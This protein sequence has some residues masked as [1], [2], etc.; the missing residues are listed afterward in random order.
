MA[1]EVDLQAERDELEA[2]FSSGAFARSPIV[3][4]MLRYICETHF[5]GQ[6]HE[7]KE[8]NIAVEAFGR[9]ADFDQTRDSIVRVEAHRLRKRLHEYYNGAGAS[10]EIQI[11][12]PPG[13]YVPQFIRRGEPAKSPAAP[14]VEPAVVEAPVVE[15]PVVPVTLATAVNGV[16]APP[17]SDPVSVHSEPARAWPGSLTR[18][19]F[20]FA[21]ALV[22]IGLIMWAPV[23]RQ[24]SVP[25]S[26]AKTGT[27]TDVAVLP[28]DEVR[29]LAGTTTASAVDHFGNTWLGDRYFQGGIARTVAPRPIVYTRDPSFYYHSREGDFTYDIPLKQGN[30][31]LRLYFAET[32]FGENNVAGGGETSRVFK[33][34]ANGSDLRGF[35]DVVADAGGSNTADVKIFKDVQPADD[36]MLHLKFATI[37]TQAP[38]VNAIELVPSRRG[39]IRP[40]RI[41]ARDSNYVDQ[42][43]RLWSADRYYRNGILVQR[44]DP[45]ANTEDEALYQS[46]R[47]GNFSYS[48]PVA[49]SGRYTVTLKFC[50]AWFGPDRPGGEGIN[51]RIF[52]ISFN[53]RLLLPNFDVL[54]EAGSLR[55]LDKTF[56]GLQPNAQGKLIFTFTPSK[57]YAIVDAIEVL[58]ENWK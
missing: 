7:I 21:G 14:Q 39:A 55:A 16:G 54:K 23:L 42:A 25:S 56:K 43:N 37:K 19:G 9:P 28:G 18:Y 2:V 4:Q 31:E 58:D 51:K 26:L 57:N 44:P 22:L 20:I 12:I 33:V 27:V 48:I 29:I 15:A 49:E 34:L 32:V 3:A 1:S 36:G 5:R 53:G 8:Y 24:K 17:P 47:F 6:S 38:F 50:E 35:L 46:E 40:I 52:D 10:H 13:S 30:Y 11:V 41:L 45:V